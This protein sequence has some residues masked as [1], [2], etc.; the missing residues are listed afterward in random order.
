MISTNVAE[1]I[2]ALNAIQ[3]RVADTR[4]V[5]EL[6][7][8][9]QTSK[10]LLDIMQDKS[11]PDGESWAPWAASTRASREKK[12]NVAQ[13]LL[14]DTGTYLASIQASATIN[15]VIIGSSDRIATWLQEGTHRMPARPVFGWTD[16][17]S[18]YV[19]T[20]LMRHIEGV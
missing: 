18:T 1:V 7:K 20:L 6:I 16:E 12:G 10:I 11:A 5:M 19:E 9:H 17:D 8:E 4:P 2:G 3:I 13:G 15:T 14:W